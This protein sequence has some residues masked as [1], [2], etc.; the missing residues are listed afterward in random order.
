MLGAD[1][2]TDR[3]AV[4]ALIGQFLVAQLRMGGRR[5][6]DDQRLDVRDVGQQGEDLE[7]VD[8]GVR[9]LLS[10]LDVEGEDA[11]PAVGE[12][13]LIQ[14]VVRVTGQRGMVDLFHLR[15]RGQELNDL[16]CV[17]RVAVEAQGQGLHAL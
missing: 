13:L 14:G 17:L 1:G 15:M 2:E 3:V 9:L 16:L 11:G 6:V 7:S 8:K 5:R 10:A 12:V 4:D